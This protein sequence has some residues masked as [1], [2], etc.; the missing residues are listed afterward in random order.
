VTG[1]ALQPMAP[2]PPTIYAARTGDPRP[3]PLDRPGWRC[4]RQARQGLYQGVKALGLRQ[5][6]EVL[7]PAYHHGS[8]VEALIAA[9][10]VCRFYEIDE[11]L[12]P[13]PGELEALLSPRTRALHLIHYYGFP[14]DAPGWRAWCDRREL[15]LLEDAA[16]AWLSSWQGRPVGSFG[17]LAIFSVYK[18]F[19]VP[20]GGLV[21]AGRPL[22]RPAGAGPLGTRPVV[23]AHLRW[24]RQRWPWPWG[25]Q[26]PPADGGYDPVGDF[27]LGDPASPPT[28]LTVALLS[29]VAAER[30][31]ARRRG[32]YQF[33][34]ARL[35]TAV[36]PVVAG[37]PEGAVPFFFPVR[38][39]D[40][41]ALLGR[42]E[43]RGV[44]ALDVWS[45][46]HPALAPT[47]FAHSRA[48][49][50]SVLGLPVHQELRRRDLLRVVEAAMGG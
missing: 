50:C 7:V 43:R 8:E 27:A 4:F 19:G 21:V 45:V 44:A 3:F 23:A 1:P 13:D 16:Q 31:R 12:A 2:L 18:T 24:L 5:G 26:G 20:D 34:Q 14:Q 25:R 29:R 30:T 47:G 11:R 32:N 46:P 41:A 42:L 33:L 6:D 17:D 28:R 9:G 48:L 39:P 35:G 15:L 38:A 22:P 10:L 49:R 40:K 36:E 37:L